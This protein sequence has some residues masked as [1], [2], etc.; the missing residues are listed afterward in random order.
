LRTGPNESGDA[1]TEAVGGLPDRAR[2]GGLS[3]SLR[4][5][6][7]AVV[8]L[9]AIP[10][11]LGA[12]VGTAALASV[13]AKVVE[14]DQRSVRTLVSLADLRDMEGDM[15]VGV[16]DLM[17]AA[18][19]DRAAVAKNFKATDAQLDADLA[20]YLREHGSR[21]DPA[22]VSAT[23]FIARLAD[24]RRIRDQQVVVAALA[25]HLQAAQAAL[26]GPLSKADDAMA[27]PLDDIFV[28]EKAA[29]DTRV[30][31]AQH[32]YD[33]ARIAVSAV[34]GLGLVLSAATAWLLIRHP[35]ALVGRITEVVV[36][37]DVE[38]RVDTGDRTDI[39]RL[40]RSLDAM[41][42]TIRQQ[43][44]DLA[45]QQAA[46]ERQ[47]ADNFARQ[48][49]AEREVRD[50]AQTIMDETGQSVL[51]ELK[52]VLEQA[53]TVRRASDEI[54]ARITDADTMTQAVVDRAGTADEVVGAVTESLRRVAGIAQLIAGVAEQTNLLALN[55]TI[56]AARAGDA[57]RG[58]SV[59]AN[60]VKELAAETGRSTGEISTT[61]GAL[62]AD[63]SAMATTIQEMSQGVST[64]SQATGRVSEVA[65]RQ[66]ESVQRLDE[67]VQEAISRIKAM[68]DLTER[69]ERRVSRRVALN[70]AVTLHV[71]GRALPSELLDLS[72]T[73]A[74]L[75]LE[76]DA[77]R[78]GQSV[79]LDAELGG[80]PITLQAEVVRTDAGT[81]AHEVA[82]RFSGLSA[83][84]QRRLQGFLASLT[85]A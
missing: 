33:V 56:E 70:L 35:V 79:T 51:T 24:W 83:Q 57:G 3:W 44:E 47:M 52:G 36:G 81:P 71:N 39:G 34:I 32:A 2:P 16:R 46:R 64:M 74:R 75:Q 49:R 76:S 21:T 82:V 50:R 15:R 55:A 30:A 58:F 66:R 26:N 80:S 1:M 17:D 5:R 78:P 28:K 72:E 13:N 22:G 68:S 8:G 38:A 7:F 60:E 45:T 19:G 37:G 61:V 31:D 65:A 48:Q 6:V 84:D 27:A 85:S 18:P 4:A 42:E 9:S 53:E 63:A 10:A 29:A 67:C 77:P 41:L 54:D 43:H 69:L 14:I 23:D 25:G 11:V 62:E 20:D 40:G 12:V 73:G 59:V